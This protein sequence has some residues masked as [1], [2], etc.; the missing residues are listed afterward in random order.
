MP[1]TNQRRRSS[2]RAAHKPKPNISRPRRTSTA[3]Q[4]RFLRG[5][6]FGTKPEPTGAKRVLGALTSSKARSKKGG[7]AAAAGLAL[8]MG[9]LTALRKR[10]REPEA[11]TP[12]PVTNSNSHS[13]A[14]PGQPVAR[15]HA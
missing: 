14:T 2:Q 5:W 9:G 15:D 13:P 7:A 8:F 3:K 6:T 4:S 10:K 12:G 1:Q 11:S